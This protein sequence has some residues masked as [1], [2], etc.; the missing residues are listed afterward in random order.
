MPALVELTFSWRELD[1]K[2]NK[3]VDDRGYLKVTVIGYK[4]KSRKCDQGV[5]GSGWGCSFKKSGQAKS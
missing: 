3:L 4:K 5:M 2:Q 1:C